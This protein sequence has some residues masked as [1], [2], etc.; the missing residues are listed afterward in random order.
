MK[1]C[2]IT[3]T[4]FFVGSAYST[5]HSLCIIIHGTWAQNESWAQ[6]GGDFF[7]N[8]R[9]IVPYDTELLSF[10][11][12]GKNSHSER[13]KAAERL[14]TLINA[15]PRTTSITIIAHSH[16]ANVAFLASQKLT[17]GR[18]DKLFAL[19]APIDCARCK[20]NMK[21]IGGLYNLFSFGDPVQTVSGYFE[22]ILPA[23]QR[24]TNMRLMLNGT[25]PN[26]AQ[27]HA[28]TVGL[29]LTQIPSL[30]AKTNKKGD[31]EMPPFVT[32][33]L[34]TTAQPYCRIDSTLPRLLDD[35]KRL[36]TLLAA[37]MLPRAKR[38]NYLAF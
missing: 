38:H 17:H 26:H 9:A 28:P 8:I 22:R 20:P 36:Y 4:L 6:P 15:T 25:N 1:R 16:G 2:V 24:C 13:V 10:S 33:E 30:V 23:H 27:L 12:S 35:E 11:W 19:G 5:P 34:F 3:I 32:L 31:T 7:E 14:A 37:Q 29:W 21:A 18:I